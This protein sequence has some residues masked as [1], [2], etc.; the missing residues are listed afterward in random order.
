MKVARRPRLRDRRGF[1]LLE[2]VVVLSVL[3]ILAAVVTPSFVQEIGQTRID[4]TREETRVLHEAMVGPS[5]GETRF[6]FVGD[7]GRL[8]N[9]FQELAQQSGL[10]A[11]TTST[12]RSVG[13]G[14]RGPYVNTGTSATD[15]LN[16]S[17]GRAYTGAPS[18]QVRSAGPDGVANNADD[19][20]YP[21]LAPTVVGS[22]TVTVKRIQGGK[23][24]VDPAGYRVDLYYASN[25]AQSSVSDTSAPFTFANVPIGL[26][27]VRVVKTSNPKAG[28]IVG[29]DT[30]VVR[31]VST[32]AIEIWF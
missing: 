4:A 22:V 6:G 31:A 9:S 17:F 27:A 25:G 8:P 5:T 19:I 30:I 7:I 11:Y 18:G 15:Y 23:T 2:V 24:I 20:V 12:V 28:S 3:A 10:P 21:P 1:T 13:M 26:H 29:E 16:D 14:W 32:T